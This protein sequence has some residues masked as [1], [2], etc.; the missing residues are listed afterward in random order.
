M[1]AVVGINTSVCR[2]LG[3]NRGGLVAVAMQAGPS[4]DRVRVLGQ[5]RAS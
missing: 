3:Q 2:E 4:S 1:M 5:H